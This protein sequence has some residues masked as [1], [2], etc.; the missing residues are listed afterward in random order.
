MVELA[1]RCHWGTDVLDPTH[2]PNWF[3]ATRLFLTFALT[4][5]FGIHAYN[6][7]MRESV[8]AVSP[9]KWMYWL[10]AMVFLVASVAYFTQF[11]VTL[12]FRSCEKASFQLGFS[13]LLLVLSYVA[14]LAGVRRK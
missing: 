3:Q 14:L 6:A 5:G 12:V 4:A 1:Y 10:Y 2:W 9:R 13:T 11:M 8:E 7:H